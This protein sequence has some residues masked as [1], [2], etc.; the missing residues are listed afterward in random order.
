MSRL[1]GIEPRCTAACLQAE[2]VRMRRCTVMHARQRLTE[3]LNKV[4][5]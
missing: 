2:D 4:V 5:E 1:S 3:D